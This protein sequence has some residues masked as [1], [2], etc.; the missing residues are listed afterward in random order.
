MSWLQLNW[1]CTKRLVLSPFSNFN[2][3]PFYSMCP[4]ICRPT[5]C[6]LH[7]LFIRY[8]RNAFNYNDDNY[9][10]FELDLSILWNSLRFSSLCVQNVWVRFVY[11]WWWF[12]AKNVLIWYE[13]QNL[14]CLNNTKQTIDWMTIFLLAQRRHINLSN[15]NLIDL[16]PSG[17]S[18]KKGCVYCMYVNVAISFSP[19]LCLSAKAC[20]RL[21][22]KSGWAAFWYVTSYQ[23]EHHNGFSHF[24]LKFIDLYTYTVPYTS[25]TK[26]NELRVNIY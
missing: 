17:Q 7:N 26:T 12:I 25:R 4:M 16:K 5:Q 9:E 13:G 11:E 3:K 23:N 20:W 22:K 21:S 15:I 2:L 8:K 10:C 24:I 19:R 1:K 18:R 6:V 14:F